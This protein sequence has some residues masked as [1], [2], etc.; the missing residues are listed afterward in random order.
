[1][2]EKK[3]GAYTRN[4]VQAA[5]LEHFERLLRL[6]SATFATISATMPRL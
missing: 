6:W 4:L 1:M 3:H 5:I 2:G